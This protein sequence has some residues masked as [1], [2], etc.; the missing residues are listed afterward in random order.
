V[1]S[2]RLSNDGRFALL[3]SYGRVLELWE[4]ADGRCLR[5][6]EGHEDKVY[7][8]CLSGDGRFALSGS[9]DKTLK[10]WFLDWELGEEL[11]PRPETSSAP[12]GPFWKRWLGLGQ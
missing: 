1:P 5:A 6:F 2:A 3:G 11:P 8:V 7:S 10:L 4:V 9:T 12:G